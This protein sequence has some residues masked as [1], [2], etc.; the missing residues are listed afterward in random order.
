MVVMRSAKLTDS[1]GVILGLEGEDRG[2]GPHIGV[3]SEYST[4]ACLTLPHSY[5][6]IT[7]LG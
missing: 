2:P 6:G 7:S 5:R 1:D 3:N 4:D